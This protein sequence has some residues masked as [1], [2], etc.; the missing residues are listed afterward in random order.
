MAVVIVLREDVGIG[1]RQSKTGER[2]H[3]QLDSAADLALLPDS[4]EIEPGSWALDT[5]KSVFYTL[6]SD[7]WRKQA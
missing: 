7:G 1:L 5:E 6:M 2:R 4:T 3:Y